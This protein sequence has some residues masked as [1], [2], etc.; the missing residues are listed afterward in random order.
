MSWTGGG[1]AGGRAVLG[2]LQRLS[3]G[4]QQIPQGGFSWSSLCLII[5]GPEANRGQGTLPKVVRGVKPSLRLSLVPGVPSTGPLQ[6]A[7]S[8][9]KSAAPGVLW[10]KILSGI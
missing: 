8:L 5:E 9:C 6:R 7:A 1:R 2:V 4:F 3:R 10:V